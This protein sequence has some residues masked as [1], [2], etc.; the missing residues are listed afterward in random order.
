MTENSMNRTRSMRAFGCVSILSISFIIYAYMTKSLDSFHSIYSSASN[1]FLLAAGVFPWLIINW[2]LRHKD[3]Y[4]W[5]NGLGRSILVM[6]CVGITVGMMKVLNS[7][8]KPELIASGLEN[9]LT[10]C[11]MTTIVSFVLIAYA[12]N[13]SSRPRNWR[14]T[15]FLFYPIATLL[16]TTSTVFV[17]LFALKKECN[18]TDQGLKESQ[19]DCSRHQKS[20]E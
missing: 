2:D 6:G 5:M 14:M 1:F 20:A 13:Y 9:A 3:R 16:I 4:L 7:L 12:Q 17:V 8:D 18:Y 11:L 19:A 10:S 15:E